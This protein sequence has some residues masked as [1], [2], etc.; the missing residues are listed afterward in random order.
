M[1]IPITW[2]EIMGIY[3]HLSI[4]EDIDLGLNTRSYQANANIVDLELLLKR[5]ST[6]YASGTGKISENLD[7][8]GTE[9]LIELF[10]TMSDFY[11]LGVGKKVPH[12][13]EVYDI[14]N[15]L[16][17]VFGKKSDFDLDDDKLE[18]IFN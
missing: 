5:L 12:A 10:N 11:S 1:L 8:E 2:G 7:E 15:T 3:Q 13:D 4:K 9:Q 14:Y 6:A 17:E 16:A 18:D